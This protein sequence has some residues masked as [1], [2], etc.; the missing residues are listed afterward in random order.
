MLIV[1]T[2]GVILGV[3][4]AVV[5]SASADAAMTE[6]EGYEDYYTVLPEEL[7]EGFREGSEETS[8]AISEGSALVWRTSCEQW[9]IYVDDSTKDEELQNYMIQLADQ[10]EES[11]FN[12]VDS[13][14]YCCMDGLAYELESRG[15][16]AD[17]F[18]EWIED[19]WDIHA[20]QD[21]Y[22]AF[23]D[24]NVAVNCQL[25]SG[26]FYN[27]SARIEGVLERIGSWLTDEDRFWV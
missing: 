2:T 8:A 14:W 3:V 9:G 10:A 5:V 7:E 13:D 27:I 26:F 16:D 18:F 22:T 4:L 19:N 21:W 20:F 25:N 11:G 24:M 12:N 15:K 6:G 17:F 1:V 23:A